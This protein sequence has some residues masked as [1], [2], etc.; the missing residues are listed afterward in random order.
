MPADR[1]GRRRG[2]LNAV[3][4]GTRILNEGGSAL[5]AVLAT[6]IAL[7]DD[8]LF[9]AGYGSVLTVDGRVEMDAGLMVADHPR[10]KA[11]NALTA[12][13]PRPP[14][15]PRDGAQSP[16]IRAGGVVTISR[17][18]NPIL[19]ARAVMDHTP[20]LLIGGSGAEAIA[21]RARIKLCRPEELVSP[22]A[23]DRWLARSQAAADARSDEAD[24][25]GTVGAVAIDRHGDLASATSTGGVAGKLA[26]RIGDSALIG[27]GLFATV[28]GAASATGTGEAIMRSGLCREALG[29]LARSEPTTA[30][31]RAIARLRDTTGGEGGII[32][33]D[34]RGRIGYAHNAQAMDVAFFVDG[35][36]VA[37]AS[38]KPIS[39]KLAPRRR[40]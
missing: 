4:L 22:R 9:N 8:P 18:R 36:T 10:S 16:R 5:D 40:I 27:A 23:R 1:P 19:L 26:G 31:A 37:F 34:R 14:M 12:D 17:V 2:L 33:A 29:L 30:A 7:E 24:R 20:H 15:H 25:H 38:A 3:A 39:A 6:V 21:R 11:P 28:A 35:S 13:G 32:I